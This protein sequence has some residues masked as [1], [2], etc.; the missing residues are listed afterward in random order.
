MKIK[1]KSLILGIWLALTLVAA[2]I[3]AEARSTTGWNSFR[4]WQ[5][6]GADNC[7][8][9]SLGAAFNRCSHNINLTFE[10]VVDTAGSKSVTVL[11]RATQPGSMTCG[12]ISF[13]PQND[14]FIGSPSQK[15]DPGGQ[16]AKTFQIFVNDGWTLSLYC[17]NVE[18]GAG[19]AN[20]NWNPV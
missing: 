14:T 7:V 5:P 18:P 2:N 13:S 20:I 17:W 16:E 19:I 12:A 8:G 4:V 1:A 15:F 3:P 11:D 10:L 9:E 6:Y